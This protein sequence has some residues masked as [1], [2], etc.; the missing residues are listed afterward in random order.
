MLQ[1]GD[2][3]QIRNRNSGTALVI[4]WLRL[5]SSNAGGA[6]LILSQGTKIPHAEWWSQKKKK[7]ASKNKQKEI[8]FQGYQKKQI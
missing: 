2:N 7:K 1:C 8:D 4:Q 3:I 6:G 5:C